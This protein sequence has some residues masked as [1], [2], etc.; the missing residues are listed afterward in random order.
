MK[1]FITNNI[2]FFA[3]GAVILAVFAIYKIGKM[4]KDGTSPATAD[5]TATE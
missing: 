3:I 4:Q 5:A 2:H 1:K